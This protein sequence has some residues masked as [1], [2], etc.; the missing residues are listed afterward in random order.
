[1][2]K[3]AS[4]DPSTQ[5][6]YKISLDNL[7]NFCMQKYGMVDFISELQTGTEDE[8]FDFLQSWIN[9]NSKLSARTVKGYF[10][11][12]KKYL[13]YRGIKLHDEDIK[14]EL[15]FRRVIE[16]E[17]YPLSLEDIQAIFNAIH[18]KAKVTLMC[19]MSALMRVGETVQLRKKHLILNKENIIV[20]LPASIT[21]F[22]KGRTTFFSK[23]ASR[24]LRPKLRDMKDN[25]LVFGT[26]PNVIMSEMNVE[27][28][29]RR[30]LTKIGLDMRYESTGRFMINT[31]S[32]RAYGI[33]KIS[34]HDPNF[35]KK[36][37][38]QKG[39]L[40]QY[41][42]MTDEEKLEVFESL[43]VDLI[44][45]NTLK[46]KAEIKKLTL[47]QDRI[48]ALEVELATIR[49]N[50]DIQQTV[51]ALKKKMKA[52]EAMIED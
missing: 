51:R 33:T 14:A 17:L 5:A 21:K 7:E 45:D 42:R 38:G 23:E 25:D 39:Y 6:N 3:I 47:D 11:G 35:A 50:P 10:S 13:H 19:Q 31:H 20:K 52:L 32:F 1:M 15:D 41:D 27:Q 16:E 36:L 29:L 30:I 26:S 43:E 8:V 28:T 2:E 22:K 34:R 4:K 18:Y 12:V 46:Q 40:L 9:S 48:K 24:L 37:A 49:N 44:I